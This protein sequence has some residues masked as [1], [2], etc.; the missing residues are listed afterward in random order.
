MIE[1]LIQRA[2]DDPQVAAG[3]PPED[4]L[5]APET[6]VYNGLYSAKRRN[7]WLLGR[8]TAK[9]LVQAAAEKS[10]GPRLSCREISILAAKD[11]SPE[12]WVGE[13]GDFR[14]GNFNISIS[15][16]RDVSL[17]AAIPHPGVEVPAAHLLGA[18]IEAIESR[19][20][21][22]IQDYFTEEEKGL[23]RQAPT[24]RIDCLITAIW[25]GKEAA[26]KA[27][28]QG[29]RLD[30][31]MVSCH[32]TY[33]GAS[34]YKQESLNWSPFTVRWI[35]PQAK[36]NYPQLTGWWRIWQDFVLTLV[37]TVDPA[38]AKDLDPGRHID[39]H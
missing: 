5:S 7:D 4:L 1:W 27:V 17:C 18:D 11:G 33:P 35:G 29:L 8:W 20:D 25:S 28:R 19:S 23:V 15:H 31:R 3:L 12:V 10:G 13:E 21:R 34:E 22:F 24:E 16:S 32:L 2:S 38:Q 30:T 14:R 39:R 36:T 26:L 37:V 6:V 9:R